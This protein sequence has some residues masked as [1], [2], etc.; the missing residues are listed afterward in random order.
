MTIRV[1]KPGKSRQLTAF[2]IS[3]LKLSTGREESVRQGFFRLYTQ[4]LDPVKVRAIIFSGC[5]F[6]TAQTLNS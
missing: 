3:P 2:V 5:V 1:I 4:K 6:F